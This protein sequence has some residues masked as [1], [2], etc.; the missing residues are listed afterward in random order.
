MGMGE[1][2]HNLDNEVEAIDAG[3]AGNIGHKN[4]VVYGG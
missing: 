3:D 2:V 4:L 1:L